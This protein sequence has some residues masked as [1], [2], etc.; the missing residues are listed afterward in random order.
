MRYQNPSITQG[1]KKLR[2]LG[3]T[4]LLL[5]PMFPH[6]AMSSYETAVERVRDTV[7][8]IATDMSL[9]IIPPYYNHPDYIAALAESASEYLSQDYDHLLF[10]FHG[11][12][13]RHLRKADPTN[14]HCLIGANC[15]AE[16]NPAHARCY[17]AQCLKTVEGFAKFTGLARNKFSIAFQSRLGREPWLRPY[18][19]QTIEHL[20]ATG[21]KKLLVICPAFVTDCLETLEEIGIR[22][23]RSFLAAGGEELTL[24]PCLNVHPR[25]VAALEKMVADWATNSN[26]HSGLKWRT[27]TANFSSE[28]VGRRD[29][30]MLA[31][32]HLR[33][34]ADQK[35]R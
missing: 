20:A 14:S 13:E 1:I 8:K 9:S 23:R 12:P 7:A 30:A 33:D 2:T 11:L 18:T 4:D 34:P 21:K 26:S 3:V 28:V 15:C 24:I 17:R 27:S 16:T 25:W 5:I 19:D 6:Y 32:S 10:S 35:Q 22:G 31:A 29:G